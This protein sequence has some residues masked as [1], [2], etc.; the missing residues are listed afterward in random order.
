MQA[1]L[2]VPLLSML[3]FASAVSCIRAERRGS[4]RALYV[5]KPATMLCV[6]AIAALGRGSATD[7]YALA[8][9]AG[10]VFSLAGDV[11]LMLPSDR[12][13]A[14]LASFLVA[15]L[16]YVA[17]FAGPTGP[18]G[19]WLGLLLFAGAA[20]WTL[21]LLL[22]GVRGGALRVAVVLYVANI[23]AMGWQ[24]SERALD[25]ADPG[26]W[27]AAAGALLF[28]GSDSALAWNRFR[29]PLRGAETWVLSTYFGG[30]WLIAL[31]TGAGE[32]QLAGASR[33]L[34]AIA[35]LGIAP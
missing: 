28:L 30:Q 31:S 8:I 23:A 32:P 24:A 27:L 34:A 35:A 20:S 13:T 11:W 12:F 17:A 4:R 18:R 3:A 6:I 9:L 5:S 25:L 2:A 7:P 10:L 1:S 19:G 16:C 33:A 21:A 14:G 22:P 26:A 15:H 29:R